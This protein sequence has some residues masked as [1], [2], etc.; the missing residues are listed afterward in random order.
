[1]SIPTY[2]ERMVVT[3]SGACEAWVYVTRQNS[4]TERPRALVFLHIASVTEPE[5]DGAER[6]RS[7]VGER[8]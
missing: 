2:L 1:M 4:G 6:S 8:P 3:R 5:A 7:I